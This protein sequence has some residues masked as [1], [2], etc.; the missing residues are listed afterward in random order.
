MKIFEKIL[1]PLQVGVFE[2]KKLEKVLC[3]KTRGVAEACI[4]ERFPFYMLFNINDW[5]LLPGEDAHFLRRM[6]AI[7][8]SF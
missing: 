7:L 6:K 8:L 3:E 5:D 2:K 4:G 1:Q